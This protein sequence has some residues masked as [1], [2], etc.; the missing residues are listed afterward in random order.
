MIVNASGPCP[1]GFSPIQ[2]VVVRKQPPME[3][4]LRVGPWPKVKQLA[5]D[6]LRQQTPISWKQAEIGARLWR[7]VLLGWLGLRR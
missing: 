3:G 4:T 1:G 5:L 2:T 7:L 6:F